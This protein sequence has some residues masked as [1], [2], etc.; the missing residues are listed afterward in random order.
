MRVYP[1]DA[2][3]HEMADAGVIP[4][5]GNAEEYDVSG[6]RSVHP[7][8]D[9]ECCIQCLFCWIYCPDNSVIVRDQEVVAFDAKHCKGCGICA[10]VCPKDCITMQPGA[11]MPEQ[12]DE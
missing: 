6:W 4:Q 5:A 8:R 2:K 11:D 1:P 9:D 10:Q 7:V 12:E 3:W